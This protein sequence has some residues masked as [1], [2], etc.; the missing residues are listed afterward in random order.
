MALY[1]DVEH[2][3]DNR[4]LIRSALVV[5]V[6][7][8]LDALWKSCAQKGARLEIQT[9]DS[10]EACSGYDYIVLAAGWGVR[11]FKECAH[12]PIQYV[13]GQK[14][15]YQADE[16]IPHSLISR[17]YLAQVGD[18]VEIGSTYERETID[19]RPDLA[20]AL[21]DLEPFKEKVLPQGKLLSC[22]AAVRVARRGTYIPIAEK[23][24][25]RTY[26]LTAM[27]SRGLLYHAYF[28]KMA[29]QEIIN[30]K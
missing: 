24:D 29:T 14:L 21:R 8:Y 12:L 2:Y 28:G 15:T 10:L 18:R 6:P 22:K 27:G 25:A 19:D 16:P 5:N 30:G 17:K 23:I 13:K 11:L 1:K 9:I 26:V 20:A 7:L 4:F 3:Q